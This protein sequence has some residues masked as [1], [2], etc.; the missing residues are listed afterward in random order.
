MLDAD[1]NKDGKITQKD[2]CTVL[3]DA[4]LTE[5]RIEEITLQIPFDKGGISGSSPRSGLPH[6][7]ATC[8]MAARQTRLSS[9]R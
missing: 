9:K 8:F 6:A 7:H 5:E 2:V 3:S 4:G 1:H